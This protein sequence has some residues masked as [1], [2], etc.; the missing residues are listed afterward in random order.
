MSTENYAHKLNT[1][2]ADNGVLFER[3]R[4]YLDCLAPNVDT[5]SSASQHE[6]CFIVSFQ[7]TGVIQVHSV[8]F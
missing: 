5:K 3:F 1:W 2:A 8:S 7:I 6:M 4:K